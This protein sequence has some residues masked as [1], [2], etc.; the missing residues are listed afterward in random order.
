[1]N[2]KNIVF[3]YEK[4]HYLLSQWH[5]CKIYCWL[6]CKS[7]KLNPLSLDFLFFF[8][9]FCMRPWCRKARW[10]V[11][12]VW[13]GKTMNRQSLFISSVLFITLHI[14]TSS[15]SLSLS[16]TFW[17]LFFQSVDSFRSLLMMQFSYLKIYLIT[18][19]LKW[20]TRPVQFYRSSCNINLQWL[21][22]PLLSVIFRI[23]LNF[24]LLLN[25][26]HLS[27]NQTYF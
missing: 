9:V 7:Y 25:T 21:F 17:F 1:M 23:Q 19:I 15:L 11:P 20:R 5:Y 27:E 26:R 12:L 10:N 4:F 2:S 8:L 14:S 22:F 18:S 13:K 16:L 6:E 24:L 3:S